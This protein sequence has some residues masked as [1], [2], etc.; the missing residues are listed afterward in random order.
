MSFIKNT[1]RYIQNDWHSYPLRFCAEAFA[2]FCSV[3]SAVMFAVTAPD[4]P[5]IPLY[6]IFISGCCASA[7]SCYTRGSFG[8]M[9]NATFLITIDMI[10][11]VRMISKSI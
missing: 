7:W 8:L 10:G 4:I 9:A 6:V 2:W 1:M 11:L 5:I 3:V